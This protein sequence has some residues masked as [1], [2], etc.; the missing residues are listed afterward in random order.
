MRE[1]EKKKRKTERERE[2]ERERMR[3]RERKETNKENSLPETVPS[4]LKTFRCKAGH[5]LIPEHILAD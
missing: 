5:N 4:P 1:R 3:E 2:R